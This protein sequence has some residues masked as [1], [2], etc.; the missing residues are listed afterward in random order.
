MLFE[1][2]WGDTYY[3]ISVSP[4]GFM[5]KVNKGCCEISVEG[6]WVR[7]EVFWLRVL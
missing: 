2:F 7:I 5:P 4:G 6:F 3:T 1:W